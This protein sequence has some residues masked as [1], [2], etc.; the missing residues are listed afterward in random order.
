VVLSTLV[1]VS[2]ALLVLG[3]RAIFWVARHTSLAPE[4]A[5]VWHWAR[6]PTTALII[7]LVTALAYYLLPDVEQRFKFITP[8]SITS[9]VLWLLATWGFTQYADN[10]TSFDVTYGSLGAA[11]VLLTWLYITAFVLILGGEINALI[12]QAS[13]EGKKPGSRELGLRTKAPP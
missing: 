5:F 6:W 3:G 11:V 13:P 8:G 10:V 12:E 1:L 9:T 4:A 7:M 2:F